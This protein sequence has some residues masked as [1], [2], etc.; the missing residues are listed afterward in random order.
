[1][2]L[3]RYKKAIITLVLVLFISISYISWNVYSLYEKPMIPDSNTTLVIVLDKAATASQFARTLKDKNLIYSNKIFLILIRG[4]GL[5]HQLKAGVYQVKP[6]E[7]AMHLLHRVV[8]GDVLSESFTIIAGTTQR[9]IAQDLMQ[10]AYLEYNSEDWSTI[11]EHYPKAEGLV[12]A[13]TYQY[14]GG[15]SSKALLEHAHKNLMTY[16]NLVW[17]ERAS[18]LPYKNPYEL[19]VAASIIEKESAI[20]DERKLIAGVMVNRLRKGMP[21]QMDPTVIYGLSGDYKGKLSHNDLLIDTPYNTYRYRGLPPTPIATVGK[22]ALEAAAHPQ[23]SDYLYYV[24]K[25]DGTHQFSETYQKQRQAIS[26]YQRKD[27]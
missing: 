24:S 19:L 7:T 17:S 14:H 26:R 5:A 13:D 21:L 6:G 22:E 8:A 25:G 3:K 23:S 18:N 9:K 16:L 1:M 15:S 10:A 11:M 4:S 20:P 27:T 12:L 2:E